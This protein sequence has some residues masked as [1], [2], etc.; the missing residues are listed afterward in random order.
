MDLVVQPDEP[1]DNLEAIA[2]LRSFA[3]WKL[4]QP[5]PAPRRKTD[6]K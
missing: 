6:P 1:K 5:E 3:E 4:A 2:W